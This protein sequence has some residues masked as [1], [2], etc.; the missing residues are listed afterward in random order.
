MATV[1]IKPKQIFDI[2]DAAWEI[3]KNGG[4]YVPCFAGDS[5]IGKSETQQAWAKKNGFAIAD[6]RLAYM[7]GPDLLGL[8][9]IAEVTVNGVTHKTTVYAL[10][11]FLPKSGKALIIFEEPNRAHESTMN[12]IMQ[13]L[14]D[15]KIG[16]YNLPE[17]VLLS[18]AI[19]PEGHYS[20][21]S[22]DPAL[23]NRVAMFDVKYDHLAFVKFMQESNFNPTLMGFIADSGLWSYKPVE[24]VKGEGTYISPRT[25]SHVNKVLQS[26]SQS[27][28]VFHELLA[29]LFGTETS[30]D[31]IKFMNELRPIMWEDIVKNKEGSLKK[32]AEMRDRRD[33]SGDMVSVTVTSVAQAFVDKKCELGLVFEIIEAMDKDQAV[34]LLCAVL[35]E[36]GSDE[37]DKLMKDYN[38]QFDALEK[39]I[40]DRESKKVVKQSKKRSQSKA[41]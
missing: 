6:V 25:I 9:V 5:G 39:R 19:N 34:N 24:E 20:V 30:S 31:F 18:L 33:Y 28:P 38:A 17:E 15:R 36:V 26:V 8:P 16:S 32:L 2:L 7:E 12:A 41:A 35:D 37:L 1:T 3:R 13:V 10:P 21:N 22:M 23:K 14:T 27:S 11:E 40:A 29:G 4:N